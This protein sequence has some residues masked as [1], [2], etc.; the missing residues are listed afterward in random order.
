M[1]NPEI[2]TVDYQGL[3]LGG[4]VVTES[5]TIASGQSVVRGEVLGQITANDKYASSV[6]G[7]A[8][9]GSETAAVIAAADIDASGGD[10]VGPVFVSGEFASDQVTF[11][12]THTAATANAD[13]LAAGISI[14]IKTPAAV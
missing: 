3:V 13:L 14:Y 4:W 12:G 8:S 9:D 1:P 2:E 5:V 7:T 6:R 10:V 11:P